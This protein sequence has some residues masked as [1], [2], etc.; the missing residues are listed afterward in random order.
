MSILETAVSL[1]RD[2]LTLIGGTGDGGDSNNV[3]K[4]IIDN[5]EY[6]V[7]NESTEV[8]GENGF[9]TSKTLL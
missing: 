3:E 7:V 2:I 9:P 8:S 5:S 6:L 4:R 1:R